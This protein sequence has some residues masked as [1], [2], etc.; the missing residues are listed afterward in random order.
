MTP[1]GVNFLFFL[2]RAKGV[3]GAGGGGAVGVLTNND[4][5]HKLAEALV[6]CKPFCQA[7]QVLH[8][9]QPSHTA[10][11]LICQKG[12]KQGEREDLKR[13]EAAGEGGEGRARGAGEGRGGEGKGHK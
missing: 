3:S 10:P 13:V 12:G 5:V 6:G 9:V 7:A 2:D 11:Q 1:N 4:Q 8:T